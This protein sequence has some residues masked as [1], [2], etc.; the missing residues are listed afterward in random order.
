MRQCRQF[1]W[2]ERDGSKSALTGGR[3]RRSRAT[4]Y[5]QLRRGARTTCRIRSPLR[6]RP[7]TAA[8]LFG[9]TLERNNLV[10]ISKYFR[11]ILLSDLD[12]K[13]SGSPLL[14]IFPSPPRH[15]SGN[16]PSIPVYPAG[17][18]CTAPP[19]GVRKITG[20]RQQGA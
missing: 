4:F 5:S 6:M 13:V 1:S 12:L 11:A 16:K 7:S 15:R 3:K 17:G 20:V 14:R 9:F 19:P 2:T 8:M 10:E 18:T